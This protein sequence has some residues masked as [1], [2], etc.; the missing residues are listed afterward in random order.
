MG[1]EYQG[2][3]HIEEFVRR[4]QN[5]GL[6]GLDAQVMLRS[7]QYQFLSI[8][9]PAVPDEELR[10]A[11]GYQL[12]GMLKGPTGDFTLDVMRRG[13]GPQETQSSHLFVVAAESKAI[14]EVLAL[15]DAMHWNIALIDV[16]ETAQRNLQG[17]LS[18]QNGRATAALVTSSGNSMILT[19]AANGVLFYSRKYTL[20]EQTLMMPSEYDKD[21][22]EVPI[23]TIAGE[24][25]GD[26]QDDT[27]VQR[28]VA[29]VQR[30]L[31]VWNR[32]WT[33]MPLDGMQIYAGERSEELSSQFALAFGE[34]ILPMDV[35]GLF[36]EFDDGIESEKA[37]C[38][39][40]LG[41]LIPAPSALMPQQ[42]NLLDQVRVAQKRYFLAPAMLKSLSFLLLVGG[43]WSSDWLSSM[44][45]EGDLVKQ[46]MA[47]Q[48][49]EIV[50][51]QG[52]IELRKK[53]DKARSALVQE[54]EASRRELLQEEQTAR[55]RHQGLLRPGWGHAARLRLVAQS[56]PAQVWVTT[57]SINQ[58]KFK[59]EGF[60]LE[61]AALSEW[62]GALTAN[63]LIEGQK[64]SSINLQ[65]AGKAKFKTSRPVWSFN[66]V[67]TISEPSA[68]SA[69]KL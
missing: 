44:E 62:A 19:I 12:K 61:P 3:D 10:S 32:S 27:K 5:L 39:P 47:V 63:P 24:V 23:S 17:A 26:S 18:E 51:A 69:V 56:I 4:L 1:V 25:L 68:K 35:S 36:P 66:L 13:L 11:A 33:S 48:S 9:A 67:S 20:L 52:S 45:T 14:G 22:S 2:A 38:L 49:R 42:I 30:S 60:T 50:S 29:K 21:T 34:T 57:M 58:G 55:Q 41:I 31:D 40:L 8:E 37:L 15:G 65:E 7:D 64:L 54:L 28:F 59:I 6:K 46:S 16:Q 53:Y 43:F